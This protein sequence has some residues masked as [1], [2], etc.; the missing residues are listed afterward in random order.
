MLRDYEDI[1]QYHELFLKVTAAS[2]GAATGTYRH[3]AAR[4]GVKVNASNGHKEG[5]FITVPYVDIV[6]KMP[7]ITVAMPSRPIYLI[8]FFM[9]RGI[10]LRSHFIFDILPTSGVRRPGVLQI[11]IIDI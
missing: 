10:I 5:H 4:H 6:P 11:S 7:A 2:N 1:L 9:R 3:A 8:S